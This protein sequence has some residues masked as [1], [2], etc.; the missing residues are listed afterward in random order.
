MVKQLPATALLETPTGLHADSSESDCNWW[1][2]VQ[3]DRL[4][5]A[6]WNVTWKLVKI[7]SSSMCLVRSIFLQPDQELRACFILNKA[8]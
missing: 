1:K 8:S 3:R 6:H 5:K 7:S 2:Q 4:E